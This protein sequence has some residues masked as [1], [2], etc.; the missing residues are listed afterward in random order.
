MLLQVNKVHFHSAQEEKAIIYKHCAC[1][2]LPRDLNNEQI[3]VQIKTD[4]EDRI[5]LL[6]NNTHTAQSYSYLLG[7]KS[8][9]IQWGLLPGYNEQEYHLGFACQPPLGES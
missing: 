7:N 5:Q 6:Q 4:I 2:V 3:L 9:C 1:I 8:H